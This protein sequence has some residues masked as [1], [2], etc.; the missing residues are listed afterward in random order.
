M[1]SAVQGHREKRVSTFLQLHHHIPLRQA[2]VAESRLGA[3][4]KR[5]L[6]TGA[7]MLTCDPVY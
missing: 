1:L 2:S 7:R 5:Y 6:S 3:S 4:W